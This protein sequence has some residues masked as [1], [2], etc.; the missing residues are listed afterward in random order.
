MSEEQSVPENEVVVDQAVPE[1]AV[2][3]EP[4][5]SEIEQEAIAQGW[6]PKGVEGKRALSAEEFLDRKPLYD[7][8]HKLEKKNKDLD[9]AVA[10]I[11]AH[12]KMVR[13]RMHKEHLE[14][15]KAAKK[16]A[17]ERMDFDTLERIDGQIENAKEEFK[18]T[19]KQIEPPKAE[20]AEVVQK[21]VESW[22]SKNTW[23]EKDAAMKRYADLE[24][25]A[26]RAENPEASFD[27]IL[28]HIEKSTKENFPEKFKNM[29][30]E[31]PAAVEGA[32]AGARRTSSASKQRTAK[33]LPE[34]AVSAMKVLVRAGA[35]KNEQDYVDDYFKYF[36][37]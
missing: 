35:F 36:K 20:A 7:R 12:E 2:E 4:E 19:V 22:V 37:E 13:E 24:G 30:R 33:D 28:S 8:L 9:K 17:F 26:Y 31:R 10:A 29:N 6:N 5:Y 11:Q 16:D 15:L 32:A 34:E 27:D 21:V 3:S 18:A 14:E 25:A 1:T 23:Y